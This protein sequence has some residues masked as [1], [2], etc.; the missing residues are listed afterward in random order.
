MNGERVGFWLAHPGRPDEFSYAPEWLGSEHARPISLSMPLGSSRYKGEV[1]TNYFDNLLPDTHSARECIHQ[2]FH[3]AS[4]GVFDLLSEI[5]RDC[6]GAIQ[7]LPEDQPPQDVKRIDGTPLTAGQIARLL[8]GL[9]GHPLVRSD[10]DDDFR[11]SLAG[12]QEKMALLRLGG[13]WHRPVGSTPSTHILKLPIGTGGGGID[14]STS[15]E[16]E[17][18]CARILHGYGILVAECRMD[19]FGTQKVLVVKRFDRRLAGDGRWI[20]RLP[21]EDFCQALGVSGA[22]KYESDGGPG[23]RRILDLLLGSSQAEA[24]RRDFLKTQMLFWMLCAIDG[25]A[26]NFSLFVEAGGGYRLAPRY[27]VLSAHPVLGTA[28]G[29][30]A[31]QKVKMSMAVE[32]RRRHYLWHTITP[33]HWEQMARSCGMAWAYPDVRNELLDATEEVIEKTAAALPR[34]FPESVAEPVFNGL[35]AAR[36]QLASSTP[37]A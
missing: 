31:P 19:R 30:L 20:I 29:K 34:G 28:S 35:K 18:L 2:Q 32:G 21:A 5:G 24:D 9:S 22:L 17:W 6:A 8:V 16:N 11:I 13:R 33:R 7:L 15:V 37:S 27:D 23:I 3:T 4:A 10:G 36:G 12:A 26:K 25:H 14:L 1:V